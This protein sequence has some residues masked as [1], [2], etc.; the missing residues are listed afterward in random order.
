MTNPLESVAARP[1][2]SP[3]RPLLLAL[4]GCVTLLACATLLCAVNALYWSLRMGPA[5]AQAAQAE[6][7]TP[8]VASLQAEFDALPAGDAAAGEQVFS[9][10]GNCQACHSLQAGRAGVGPSLA[11]VA[12]R[13]ES[14]RPGYSAELYLYESIVYPSAFAA[15]GYSA[16]TMPSSFGDTLTDQQ[17]ADLI[18]WLSTQE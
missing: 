6:G 3:R 13:A 16:H 4:A 5:Y 2:N 7:D 15:E 11:G 1:A 10:R 14:R 9:A 17:L 8:D 18:A 12:T